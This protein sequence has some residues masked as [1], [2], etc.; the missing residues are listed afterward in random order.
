MIILQNGVS[1]RVC[2]RPLIQRMAHPNEGVCFLCE[3]ETCFWTCGR[4]APRDLLF[5]LVFGWP[6]FVVYFVFSGLFFR[7]PPWSV[8]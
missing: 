7:W 3:S 6:L 2:T 1:E 4:E 8:R 5:C